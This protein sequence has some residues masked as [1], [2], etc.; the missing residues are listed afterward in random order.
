MELPYL[1]VEA[2]SGYKGEET[3]RAFTLDG[4]R[5]SV[6]EITDRWY[7]DTHCYFRLVANDG[8]RYVLRFQLDEERWE[9]VMQERDS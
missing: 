6:G 2:Y 9:L 8:L 4:A 1:T 3:P 7:G 5:L